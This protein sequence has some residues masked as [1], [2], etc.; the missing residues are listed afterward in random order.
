MKRPLSKAAT[1]P[2]PKTATHGSASPAKPRAPLALVDAAATAP[3]KPFKSFDGD[4]KAE[5]KALLQTL[6]IQLAT[7]PQFSGI[8]MLSIEPLRAEVRRRQKSDR[9]LVYD[10]LTTFTS[11]TLEELFDDTHLSAARVCAALLALIQVD[12]VECRP[13]GRRA[14]TKLDPHVKEMLGQIFARPN[15]PTLKGIYNSEYLFCVTNTPAGSNF[16]GPGRASSS[17]R[18]MTDFLQ[19]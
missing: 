18:A 13:S 5:A 7:Y 16:T 15:H 17:M 14:G 6:E 2:S 19:D 12:L 1:N 4:P 8:L 3:A 9:D 10:V 11:V